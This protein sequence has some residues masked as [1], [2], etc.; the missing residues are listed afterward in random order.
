MKQKLRTSSGIVILLALLGIVCLSLGMFFTVFG[1]TYAE[2]AGSDTTD[3]SAPVLPPYDSESEPNA[4]WLVSSNG[5]D[6]APLN[7]GG[8]FKYLY[9]DVTGNGNIVVKQSNAGEHNQYVFF[10]G[11]AATEYTVKLNPD[12]VYEGNKLGDTY[13]LDDADY[14]DSNK[15]VGEKELSL[16]VHTTVTVQAKASSTDTLTLS[17]TWTIATLSNGIT[18]SIVDGSNFAFG[19]SHRGTSLSAPEQ[20]NIV[21]YDIAGTTNVHFAVKYEGSLATYFLDATANSDGILEVVGNPIDVSAIPS[22]SNY[23]RQQM[24]TLRAGDYVMTVTTSA[25]VSENVYYA[26]SV[27]TFGFKVS[28]IA[29]CDGDALANGFA[30]QLPENSDKVYNGTIYNTPEITLTYNGITLVQN[31]DYVLTTDMIDVCDNANIVITGSGNAIEGTYTIENAFSITPAANGWAAIPN[32]MRWQYGSFNKQVNL[33]TAD[34]EFGK[35]ELY[36]SIYAEGNDTAWPGLE[37]I[38]LDSEGFVN[39]AQ[40]SILKVLPAGNYRLSATVD[41]NAN[42]DD[43]S[44]EITFQVFKGINSWD[45]GEIPSIKP[46]FKGRYDAEIN[47]INAKAKFGTAQVVIRNAVTK[48]VVYATD[49]YGKEITNALATA[50]V[51]TYE[52]TATVVGTDNYDK[53]STTFNFEISRKGLPVW[54]VVLIVAGALGLVA[55][56]FGILHQ[57]G[58]LQMLTGKVIIAMRT[59]A[60]V[61]ATIA[62]VRANRVA[63]EVEASIAAAKAREAEEAKQ[64]E[65]K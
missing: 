52:F 63:R 26:S 27:D 18:S 12:Y 22:D 58:V 19:D 39:E 14:S 60:N 9:I 48:E 29:L 7:D 34:A 21:V 50:G 42:Y 54:A 38:Y 4:L 24:K 36:F 53:L 31:V 16:D 35:N 2:E 5:T 20:G 65:S 37:K 45:A 6:F 40:E 17:K 23:F 44:G 55:L 43:L 3:P 13:N 25:A 62:A 47:A 61:D 28:S 64:K 56:V 11:N 10:D 15:G 8:T 1:I 57:K 49:I 33:L 41:G 30:Y 46:W 51:G 59:R 32:I